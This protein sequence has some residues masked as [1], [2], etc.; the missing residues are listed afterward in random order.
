VARSIYFYSDSVELGGAELALLLLAEGLGDDWE[1]TLLVD[2][3]PT[4]LPL[5]ERAEAIGVRVEAVEPMPLGLG[6]VAAAARLSRR[7]RRERPAIF[8]AHLSWPLAAKWALA[9]AV[10][11]RVPTVATVHLI[12]DFE[13]DR[14]SY[15]QLRALSHAV[16]RYIAVSRAL[17]DELV[18]RFDWPAGKVKV[19]YN[20]VRIERFGGD[21]P[22]GLRGEIAADPERPLVLTCARLDEQKGLDVLLRAAAEVTEASFAIAGTGPLGPSLEGLAKELGLGER[23]RFL[24]YRS[25][26]ADL[27][28]CADVFALPSLY[29]G[30][31]L[32]VLEA[33]A[34]RRALV[35]SAIGGT[36]EVVVDGESGLL[37]P[38][39]DAPALAAA[40]RRLL[41]D[42]GLRERL[43]A[44]ARERVERSFTPQVAR[45][46]V[47]AI[48]REV[49]GP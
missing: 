3:V 16:G 34:A 19:V 45:Q 36:S 49:A 33:M 44:A 41:G 30:S 38:P 6:G 48:Y 4:S 39:S 20:A 12:P 5:R 15:W 2:D 13:L 29:E 47:E 26:V 28:G 1:P 11:A 18:E 21:P 7:L 35:S 8:H 14:S 43:G 22:P 9:A 37:V 25:D 31:P 24:G 10:A 32:A 27:L 40:L 46:Q 17:G 42:P 23:V